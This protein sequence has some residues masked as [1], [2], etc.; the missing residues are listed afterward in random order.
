MAKSFSIKVGADTKEF[1]QSLRA[2]D[3]Q[4]RTTTRLGDA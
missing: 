4:I 3:N 2:T 1:N